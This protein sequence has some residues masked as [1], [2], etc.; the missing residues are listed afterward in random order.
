L[1]MNKTNNG[2]AQ[3]KKFHEEPMRTGGSRTAANMEIDR[4]FIKAL[5][6][7]DEAKLRQAVSVIA[8]ALG[9]DPVRAAFAAHNVEAFRQQ[10][11]AM[12]DEE[13]KKA[14][15]SIPPEKTA[16]IMRMLG[17]KPGTRPDGKEKR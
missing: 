13:L 15:A 14:A 7:V 3:D 9:A 17:V 10:A 16:E 2:Q 4:E 5:D 12:S 8:R 6:G 11:L 1:K